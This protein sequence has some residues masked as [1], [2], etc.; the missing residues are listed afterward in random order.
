MKKLKHLIEYLIIRSLYLLVQAMPWKIIL[1]FSSFAAL[2]F[3]LIKYRK[4]VIHV[5]FDI[6]FPNMTIA[7]KHNLRYKF[8]RHLALFFLEFIQGPLRDN[9]FIEK[10]LSLENAEILKKYKNQQ[11]LFITAHFGEF[12]LALR[13]VTKFIGKDLHVIMKEQ[14]NPYANTFMMGQ[15]IM[16]GQQPILSKGALRRSLQLV[17]SGEFLGF[18]NDQNAWDDGMDVLFFGKVAPT[19]KGLAMLK[20]RFD[21]PVL[22]G[23]VIRDENMNYRFI[24]DELK[25]EKKENK[26]DYYREILQVSNNHLEAYIKKTPEQYLWSHK[27]WRLTYENENP[28]FNN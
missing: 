28:N 13:I 19:M 4:H 21:I 8:Y 20:E 3:R 27:R 25:F 5:N 23:Y 6:A 18:L 12:N 16:C 10:N 22:Q 11:F 2:L 26:E 17:Q 7:E 24:I 15:R 9:D 1:L 14:R